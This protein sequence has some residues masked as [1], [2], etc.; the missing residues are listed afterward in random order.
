M[1]GRSS[2]LACFLFTSS[3]PLRI[4]MVQAPGASNPQ[5]PPSDVQKAVFRVIR[6]PS[7]K[8]KH[9]DWLDQRAR[10]ADMYLTQMFEMCNYFI[11]SQIYV[12]TYSCTHSPNTRCLENNTPANTN[13]NKP[14]S[15]TSINKQS[16]DNYSRVLKVL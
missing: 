1:G 15:K 2:L 11:F 3:P 16:N 8:S 9:P 14:N 13:T 4:E 5:E 7:D 12:R 10:I 6:T